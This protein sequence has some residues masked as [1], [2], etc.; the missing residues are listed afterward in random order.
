MNGGRLRSCARSDR[1]NSHFIQI[2]PA[3]EAVAA[4][5]RAVCRSPRIVLAMACSISARPQPPQKLDRLEQRVDWAGHDFEAEYVPA[6][7]I[8]PLK[9]STAAW[10]QANNKSSFELKLEVRSN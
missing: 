5:L 3:N 1:R 4:E 9:P 10:H 7:V 8:Q 6:P 2:E